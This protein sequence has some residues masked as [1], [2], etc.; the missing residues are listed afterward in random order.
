MRIKKR[1]KRYA[2]NRSVVIKRSRPQK[3]RVLL[4]RAYRG[5]LT[6]KVSFILGALI[7]ILLA[8]GYFLFF[9]DQF[10]IKNINIEGAGETTKSQ[11]NN[12]LESVFNS[13]RFLI[14][15]Q[16]RVVSFP[17][18]EFERNLLF[19]IPK[20]K[21]ASVETK[22]PGS[23]IIKVEERQQDGIWCAY[24][25]TEIILSCYFYDKDGVVYEEAPNSLKG[26]LIKIIRDERVSEAIL[27]SA[28]MD[29]DLL[30]YINNLIGTLEI[31]YEHPNYI[32]IKNNSEIHAVFSAGWEAQFSRSQ[33]LVESVEN[34]ILILE[35]EIGTRI[36][37]LEYVDLRLGNK[38]FYKWQGGIE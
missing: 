18:A 16:N 37:E 19:E 22:S 14:L 27:G 12:L 25:N 33:N 15:K 26:S 4:L 20:I 34:L 21:I 8:L 1:K 3:K 5:L 31:A 24:G 28:V 36:G 13:K 23:I 7:L 10:L 2:N 17:S 6:S 32:F 30:E 11:I 9:T 29:M 38:A 35:E